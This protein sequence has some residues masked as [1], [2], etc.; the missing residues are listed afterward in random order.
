MSVPFLGEKFGWRRWTA[1]FIGF[2]GVI[3][4]LRPT[5]N[6]ISEGSIF[7]L[8]GAVMFAVYLILTRCVSRQDSAITS[9]FWTGIGGTVTMSIISVFN[10]N[11]ILEEDYLWLFI[12]CFLSASSHFMMVK[13]LQVAEASVIQPFS[14]LQL[15]FGSIIGVTIFSESINSMIVIGVIVVIGSGLFTTWRE[16]KKK[17]NI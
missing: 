2:I 5:S 12:M 7:A 17:Y 3:I 11:N 9:F 4:I 1:I 10:W 6:I 13:T 14:Y 15:V 16:Y 8:I